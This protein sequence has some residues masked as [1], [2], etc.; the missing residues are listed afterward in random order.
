[1]TAFVSRRRRGSAFV[2]EYF[3]NCANGCTN[4]LG[5]KIEAAFII[6][7][8]EAYDV[9]LCAPCKD[10]WKAAYQSALPALEGAEVRDAA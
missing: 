8:L 5:L 7:F 1:M 4:R 9:P 10:S 2:A 3:T 6:T